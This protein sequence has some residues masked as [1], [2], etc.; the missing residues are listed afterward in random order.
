MHKKRSHG[1][2]SYHLQVSLHPDIDHTKFRVYSG[3]GQQ[4]APIVFLDAA[5]AIDGLAAIYPA[6]VTRLFDLAVKR[7]I[8]N[9]ALKEI[10][11]LQFA[12]SQ[13]EEFIVK[14]GI[15]G[16][17]EGIY[18]ALGMGTLEGGR[19]PLKGSIPSDEWEKWESATTAMAKIEHNL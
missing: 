14:W 8:T 4:L 18:R 15:A 5:G 2:V 16:I 13:A 1:N 9:D 6:T 11:S 3:F 19:L 17:R 10:Q 12:V 7:P